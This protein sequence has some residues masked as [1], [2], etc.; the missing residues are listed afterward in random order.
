MTRKGEGRGE[1]EREVDWRVEGMGE[2]ENCRDKWEV[3][4]KSEE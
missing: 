1:S 2:Q 4:M 3:W